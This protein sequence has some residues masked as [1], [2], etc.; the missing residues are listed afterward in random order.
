MPHKPTATW[1]FICRCSLLTLWLEKSFSG[2][3]GP[4]WCFPY[5]VQCGMADGFC[6]C[7]FYCG[8]T[9][10]FLFTLSWSKTLFCLSPW[11]PVHIQDRIIIQGVFARERGEKNVLAS[12]TR[13]LQ[14]GKTILARERGVFLVAASLWDEAWKDHFLSFLPSVRP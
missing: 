7:C 4:T 9:H 10:I 6:I 1:Q 5:I 8:E 11:A 13:A 14:K 2:R 12:Y 3:Q